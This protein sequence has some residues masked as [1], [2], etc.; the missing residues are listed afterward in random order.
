MA[1]KQY[2]P[3]SITCRNLEY[4]S[5]YDEPTKRKNVPVNWGGGGAAL[6]AKTI[7]I[8]LDAAQY[9]KYSVTGRVET[10]ETTPT[11]CMTRLVTRRMISSHFHRVSNGT[12]RAFVS[13][14][15]RTGNRLYKQGWV[16]QERFL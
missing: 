8:V 15:Y 4:C 13:A 2:I 14:S 12:T 7:Q 16:K 5:G 1:S 11:E 10:I 3:Q 6:W 9:G